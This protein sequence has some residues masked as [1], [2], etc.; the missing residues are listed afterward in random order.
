MTGVGGWAIVWLLLL[1]LLLS[2]FMSDSVLRIQISCDFAGATMTQG[3]NSIDCISLAPLLSVSSQV[4][5]ME[6]KTRK[7]EVREGVLLSSLVSVQS[8]SRVQLFGTP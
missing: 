7:A 5:P 4:Q 3:M 1:L 2:R 6:G 8:L